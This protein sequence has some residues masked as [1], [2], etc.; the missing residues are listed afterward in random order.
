MVD[1][2]Y[3]LGVLVDYVRPETILKQA[4]EYTLLSLPVS[5]INLEF[6]PANGKLLQN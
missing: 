4:N 6:R 3:R 1:S 2:G 5:A